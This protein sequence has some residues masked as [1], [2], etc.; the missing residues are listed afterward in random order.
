[1]VVNGIEIGSGSIR[2]HRKDMQDEIFKVIGITK[3]EADEKFGFLTE[4]LSFGAPPLGGIALGLD[5]LIAILAGCESIREVIAFPKTQKAICLLTRAPS[6]VT[7]KQLD[8]M[9]LD[10]KG[11]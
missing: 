10:I 4:A 1:M 6:S 8:E 2:I 3:E 7:D 11:E 9:G 5:R